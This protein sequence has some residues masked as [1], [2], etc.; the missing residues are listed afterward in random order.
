MNTNDLVALLEQLD[1][2]MHRTVADRVMAGTP[3]RMSLRRWRGIYNELL[4]FAGTK[5]AR[6]L[7]GR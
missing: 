6:K 2:A 4:K 1:N 7:M 3:V 5:K